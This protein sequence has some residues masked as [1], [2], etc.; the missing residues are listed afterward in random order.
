MEDIKYA[1]NTLTLPVIPMRGMWIFPHTVIHFDVGREKSINALDKALLDNSLVFLTS[2][3]DIKIEDPTSKDYY[4]I[5][6][7]AEVKQTLK[8]P[9]GSIREIGRAHV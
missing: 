1:I 7:I 2:Q 5:G 3:K 4:N 6:T 9:N 8:M